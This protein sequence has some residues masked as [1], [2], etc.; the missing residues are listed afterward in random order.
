MKLKKISLSVPHIIV[1]AL[2]V[3]ALVAEV[4]FLFSFSYAPLP[5]VFVPAV[6]GLLGGVALILFLHSVSGAAWLSLVALIADVL[7]MK[8][9]GVLSVTVVAIPA[10]VCLLADV[11]LLNVTA[12]KEAARK[13]IVSLKRNPSIIP[14]VMLFVTFLLYSL[15]LTSVANT[16]AKIQGKGM[17]LCEFVIML[18]SLLSMVCMLNAF[19]RRKKPNI[20]M[21]ILMFVMFGAIIYCNIHYSN[22][23]MAALYRPESPIKLDESTK[24]IADAYNMLGT[25]M[26]LVIITAA[27]VAL[28]PV[29]SKLLKKIN[30]SIAVDDNG[31][32][33]AIE[34]NE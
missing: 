7:L 2:S 5:L 23:V 6:V 21:I 19:P 1:L 17:G 30:T 9:H 4:I 31:Q 11:L 26:I 10:I 25:H 34:I 14:L 24:Y 3:L 27:L 20:A 32:M 22:A 15:N 33:A 16:T 8:E 28:L 12:T 29:Y 13:F 18:L